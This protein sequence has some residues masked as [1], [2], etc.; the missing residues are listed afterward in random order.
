MDIDVTTKKKNRIESE[1]IIELR[2]KNE[3]TLVFIKRG[4]R[5]G[6]LAGSRYSVYALS[7]PSFE[8]TLLVE[9]EAKASPPFESFI[10]NYNNQLSP[11]AEFFIH[12]DR[13]AWSVISIKEGT[14]IAQF[15]M[16]A[17][18]TFWWWNDD[19]SACLLLSN[20]GFDHR[21]WL[22]D[23]QKDTLSDLTDQLKN[24][25]G[26]E[27]ETPRPPYEGRVWSAD[28]TW[29][30]VTGV[31]ISTNADGTEPRLIDKDWICPVD[32]G[33]SICVQDEMGDDFRRP[34]LSPAGGFLAIAKGQN[35]F[36][37]S[38]GLFVCSIKIDSNRKVTFGQPKK[39]HSGGRATYFFWSP[40]GETLFIRDKNKFISINK[41]QM[42]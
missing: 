38:G 26:V 7:L 5:Q 6:G 4:Q 41:E 20:E 15:P 19:S 32:N 30:L 10:S 13:I 23:R 21:V 34:S 40:D 25:S 2:W 9:V 8:I 29:Y 3:S 39:V 17:E 31:G 28:G 35:Y 11:N 24:M 42:Q 1:G 33:S 27:E 16:G 14:T 18:P 22:Y 37:S 12:Y 36:D